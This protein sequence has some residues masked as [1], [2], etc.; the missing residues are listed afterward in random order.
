M[1]WPLTQLPDALSNLIH[2]TSLFRLN[3]PFTFNY[4]IPSICTQLLLVRIDIL[5]LAP[6]QITRSVLLQSEIN[7]QIVQM[8]AFQ[9]RQQI[10]WQQ[11]HHPSVTTVNRAIHLRRHQLLSRHHLCSVSSQLTDRQT[12][13]RTIP[14]AA[15]PANS[16]ENLLHVKICNTA[17]NHKKSVVKRGI[18]ICLPAI[19]VFG[20]WPSVWYSAVHVAHHRQ[21]VWSS[22]MFAEGGNDKRHREHCNSRNVNLTC[23]NL[24][25]SNGWLTWCCSEQTAGFMDGFAAHVACVCTR[26]GTAQLF[27]SPVVPAKIMIMLIALETIE[28][29]RQGGGDLH[30]GYLCRV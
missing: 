19:L 3:W 1:L 29:G 18:P 20:V 13:F 14:S 28:R 4:I 21:S 2:A 7:V 12:R 10:L 22:C 23:T 9:L 27:D 17:G 25:P 11:I 6:L 30:G 24:C 16:G 8:A 5:T 26:R 15:E